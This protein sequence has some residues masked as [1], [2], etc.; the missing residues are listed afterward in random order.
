[1]VNLEWLRYFQ[2]IA[3]TLSLHEA[4]YRLN[5]T[6]QALSK[7]VA[8]L[9]AHFKQPLLVRDKRIRALTPGG[10]AL[11]ARLPSLLENHANLESD[12]AGVVLGHPQGPVSIASVGLAHNH[13]LPSI[14][15]DLT[16]RLPLVCPR[17]YSMLPTETERWVALGEIDLGLLFSP[18]ASPDLEWCV[19]MSSPLVI[20]GTP[21]PQRAWHEFG[22]VV[23][24]LF[25]REG[26]A[27]LDG[28][29]EGNH[30]RRVIAEV[31]LLEV[32][33]SL[34]EAG[35][36]AAYV[37]LLAVRDRIKSGRLAVVATP[38]VEASATLY[39]AWR[40]GVTPTS[41][42]RALIQSIQVLGR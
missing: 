22:F 18:P 7:A 20:V 14:L 10:E 37:P 16:Q 24:R 35:V 30:R 31:D 1:M 27:S 42:A 12:M 41:A 28:W 9:E 36:G 5:V 3:Q 25:R 15:A 32:A 8:G 34:C 29:P 38:P 4:A 11:L 13:L 19:G 40:A 6:P 33:I 39:I 2:V 21:Q 23:P 17:L 26:I